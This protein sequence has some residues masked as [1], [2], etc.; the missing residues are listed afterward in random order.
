[1]TGHATN[2]GAIENSLTAAHVTSLNGR[3][4]LFEPLRLRGRIHAKRREKDLSLP[5]H[6]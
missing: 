4:Q 1:M 6:G 3:E 5:L 2:L